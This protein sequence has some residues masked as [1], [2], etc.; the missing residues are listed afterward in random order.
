MT[1]PALDLARHVDVQGPVASRGY[2]CALTGLQ[3]A[4]ARRRPGGYQPCLRTAA[5]L[6]SGRVQ[7]ERDEEREERTYR[8]DPRGNE[9][10]VGACGM[11]RDCHPGRRLAVIDGYEEVAHGRISLRASGDTH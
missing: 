5:I 7:A 9:S 11:V 4:E 10:P 2:G 8:A 3:P 1:F 6:S